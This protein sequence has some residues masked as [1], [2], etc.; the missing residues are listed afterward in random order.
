MDKELDSQSNIEIAKEWLHA[1][2]TSHSE[3]LGTSVPE[4]PT[5]VIDVGMQH[6]WTDLHIT[7]ARQR[8]AA[9]IALSHCWGG[10]I[11]PVLTARTIQDFQL[12]LP[13]LE[14][15]S[16]FQD[17]I[18]TT[19]RLGIRYL[20]IDSLCIVQD[21]RED[22]AKE[23]K[24]MGSIYCNSTL[25]IS[26]MASEG[27]KH[28]IIPQNIHIESPLPEPTRIR[29]SP[30]SDEAVTVLRQ[31]FVEETL[32]RLETYGPLSSRGWCLQESVLSPRHLYYGK[33]QVYWRC[34]RGYQAAD[35]TSS[36]LRAPDYPIPNM[37]S[38]LYSGTQRSQTDQLPSK[39][40]LLQ[41]YYK[42]VE[43][44]SHRSLTY[45]SDK[46]PAFSGISS[47]LH[48]FVGRNY[49]AGLWTRDL[50][51]GLLWRKEMTTCKHEKI[52]RA[53]S[54][55]WAVTDERLLYYGRE[56]LS[57][58]SMA[59]KLVNY[60]IHLK[61]EANPY[62]EVQLASI[63]IQGLTIPL[64]RSRQHI[65]GRGRGYYQGDA[66]LDDD[67]PRY[68]QDDPNMPTVVERTRPILLIA[69]DP[70]GVYLLAITN[71]LGGSDSALE[72]EHNLFTPEEYLALIVHVDES[73]GNSAGTVDC[74]RGLV[75]QPVRDRREDE[76]AVYERVGMFEFKSLKLSRLEA[77][78][79]RTLLLV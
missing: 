20:W 66:H 25:T 16:N 68:E 45:P 69:E 17:A 53:P 26:V 29:I 59:I 14:L 18:T 19:R 70:D 41:D 28:G 79:R 6:D 21:S 64:I 1:C 65:L 46:L 60:E 56:G 58:S 22:W 40:L 43:L 37:S 73:Q 74:V 11:T 38:I 9:Y 78:E 75:I 15:P 76:Y 34:P 36:G 31:N 71:T 33:D 50:P 24:K 51:L 4:L 2:Q 49:L 12:R 63:T 47:R 77:W 3:C 8:R 32:D 52:Y 30:G 54:W 48:P 10:P 7:H 39:R 62:G 23:S 72:I 13:F 61:D 42:L 27:S 67:P 35:G 57:E 44:Y 55:S 5:R